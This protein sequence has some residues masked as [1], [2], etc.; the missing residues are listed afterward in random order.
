M[1]TFV[2][3]NGM[4]E[5]VKAAFVHRPH[6]VEHAAGFVRMEV[7]TPLDCPDEIWLLTYWSDE[8]S[9]HTWHHSPAH[10]DSHRGIPK[11]LKLA[12]KQTRMRFFHQVC[13]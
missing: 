9:F 4:T 13:A 1:S 6:L 7:I 8:A 10:H 2:I 5:A 11:G 3:A 12:P